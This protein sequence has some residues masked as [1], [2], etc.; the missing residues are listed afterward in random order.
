MPRPVPPAALP[1]LDG[2]LGYPA[3]RRDGDGWQRVGLADGVVSERTR[4]VLHDRE[5][6]LWIATSVGL[7]INNVQTND[8]GGY[9]VV[10][11]NAI[12][13]KHFFLRK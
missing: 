4:D 1:R 11:S 8:A 6:N 10:V 7:S 3:Y 2:A 12:R 13:R 5:G 9:T